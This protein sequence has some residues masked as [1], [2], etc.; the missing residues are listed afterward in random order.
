MIGRN[1]PCAGPGIGA[2][3]GTRL[4]AI[5]CRRPIRQR[6][7]C[8][9]QPVNAIPARR[10]TEHGADFLLAGLARRRGSGSPGGSIFAECRVE[11][12]GPGACL[13]GEI[14]W[15]SGID[16]TGGNDHEQIEISLAEVGQTA[17]SVESS[18]SAVQRPVWL[19]VS[20][21]VGV[22]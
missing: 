19:V 2:D 12:A 11:S 5:R 18:A 9:I 1:P 20:I 13:R 6:Q 8:P 17:S 10:E 7:G 15:R 3:W 22:T 16:E 21:V 4:S 14:V